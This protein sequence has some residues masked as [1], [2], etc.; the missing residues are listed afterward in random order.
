MP[1]KIIRV[2]ASF[3]MTTGLDLLKISEDIAKW[4]RESKK[5]CGHRAQAPAG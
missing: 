4:L 5:R 2:Q 1:I 3:P